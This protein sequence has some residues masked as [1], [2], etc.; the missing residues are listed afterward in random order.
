MM[1]HLTTVHHT[2]FDGVFSTMVN[3]SYS[4]AGMKEKV[5]ARY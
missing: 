3:L 4:N 5:N 2:S 1:P